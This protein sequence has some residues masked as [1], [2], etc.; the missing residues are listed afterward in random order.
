MSIA[1]IFTSNFQ[2][3]STSNPITPLD[4]GGSS[5]TIS[6]Y[7][8][9]LTGS[10]YGTY[11]CGL[12][13]PSGSSLGFAT[14]SQPVTAG[15]EYQMEI[16]VESTQGEMAIGYYDVTNSVYGPVSSYVNV[17]SSSSGILV[18]DTLPALPSTCTSAQFIIYARNTPAI[19]I[20][21]IGVNLDRV[22]ISLV[23]APIPPT[24]THY[25]KS[26]YDIQYTTGANG[27]SPWKDSLV[28]TSGVVTATFRSGYWIQDSAAAWNGIYVFDNTNTPAIGDDVTIKAEVDEFFTLTELKNVD[29]LIINSS[30]NAL[31]TPITINTNELSTEEKYEGV[32]CTVLAGHCIDP[33]AGNG[34]WLFV[35]RATDTAIVDDLIFA[36]V[37]T[38][39]NKYDVTGIVHYSF[40]NYKIEPRDLA[41]IIEIS[42]SSIRENK[43]N[44][45]VYPNP[46]TDVVTIVGLI[47][48]TIEI[49]S[50][51]GKLVKSEVLNENK[52]IRV[53]DLDKGV[54]LIK[55]TTETASGTKR[56]VKN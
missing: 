47:S 23:S 6:T 31:P 44:F 11:L 37:P 27:A 56:F 8:Q 7:Y 40:D 15:A 43:L 50:L 53:N 16:F 52:L 28:E 2:A 35:N 22:V 51:E 36:Y 42:T 25:S 18:I 5:S 41:D 12:Q 30:G 17:T 34:E 38:L 39:N 48:A 1:Q 14:Q 46:A 20:G 45:S 54:Y 3:W 55:I 33:S 9:W 19:G 29:T 49:F 26:I 24:P 32:L 21:N 13:N 4:W 10:T